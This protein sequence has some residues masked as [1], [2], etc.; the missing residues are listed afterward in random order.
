MIDRS[1]ADLPTSSSH[2]FMVRLWLEDLG[3]GEYDWRGKVQYVNSGEARYFHDW[4][5]LELFFE[6][7]LNK[8]NSEESYA[9]GCPQGDRKMPRE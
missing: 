5:T 4:S 3:N 7:L 6:S 8:H 9:K 2:L 1:D